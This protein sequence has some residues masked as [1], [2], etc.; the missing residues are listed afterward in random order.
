[1]L[2]TKTL[3]PEENILSIWKVSSIS[4]SR[5]N[6]YIFSSWVLA[7]SRNFFVLDDIVVDTLLQVVGIF[8]I[9]P[10][11][12]LKTYGRVGKSYTIFW[13]G[14]IASNFVALLSVKL[15]DYNMT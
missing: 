7:E 4:R 11:P 10:V 13:P 3:L 5:Y 6:S 12:C 8:A 9:F 2:S 14:I 1:L 15:K